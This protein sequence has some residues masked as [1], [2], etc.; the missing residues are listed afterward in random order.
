MG[1]VDCCSLHGHEL[2]FHSHDHGPL[3]VHVH[4]PGEWDIRVD[5]LRTTETDLVFSAKWPRLFA[6]P[7]SN[8]RR[9]LCALIVEHREALLEEW[10]AKVDQS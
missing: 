3:H 1:K 10:H 2:F 8:S 7:R 6:G 9:A 4:R 5:L